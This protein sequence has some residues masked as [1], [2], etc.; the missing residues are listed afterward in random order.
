M[1][2]LV[3]SCFFSCGCSRDDT[4][5]PRDISGRWQVV[6]NQGI[7]KPH[8]FFWFMM[9]Y[10]EFR[11]DGAVWALIHWPPGEGDDIRLNAVSEYNRLS[12]EQ[13]QFTGSCRYEDPC[14]GTYTLRLQTDILTINDAA[15]ELVLKWVGPQSEDTVPRVIGP[16]PTA[17]PK[18]SQ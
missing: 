8:S 10:I 11:D 3:F 12:E 9:D 4:E 5:I 16:A 14:I 15:G 18:T 1:A 7:N 17:T 2:V 13:I 6:S